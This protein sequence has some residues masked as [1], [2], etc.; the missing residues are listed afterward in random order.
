MRD[1]MS[2]YF[3]LVAESGKDTLEII[4]V[5]TSRTDSNSGTC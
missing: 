2:S 1:N 3:G 4:S 5:N